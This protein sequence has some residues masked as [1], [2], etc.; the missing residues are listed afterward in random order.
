MA[1]I[2]RYLPHAHPNELPFKR[3]N[4]PNFLFD[5]TDVTRINTSGWLDKCA[6]LQRIVSSGHDYT[7]PNKRPNTYRKIKI[8]G[9]R[10]TEL[11]TSLYT[12]RYLRDA[13]VNDGWT[14]SSITEYVNKSNITIAKLQKEYDDAEV[15]RKQYNAD[16]NKLWED[17]RPKL[18]ADIL[19]LDDW[20][21][22]IEYDGIKYGLPPFVG[23]T[24]RYNNC[25]GKPITKTEWTECHLCADWNGCGGGCRH[26]RDY[27]GCDLCGAYFPE[28]TRK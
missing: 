11:M 14:I 13:M 15:I 4:I 18:E 28:S 20:N 2:K 16:L 23:D 8:D 19:A 7:R 17:H 27:L 9:Y 22:F 26:E 10:H 5:S 24:H 21:K 3:C 12:F 6:E 1:D 25:M